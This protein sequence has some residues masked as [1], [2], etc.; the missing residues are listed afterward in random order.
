M[1]NTTVKGAE[2][3]HG[4]NPQ[5]LVERVIRARIYD[6]T[7]W[8]QDCF[9]LTAATLVD[10]AAEL[11]YVGGTY[12]MLR[13]SP[14][15]CLLLKM[16]QL[17]PEREIVL[18]YLGATELKYVAVLTRYLRAVAAMYVRLVFK[19]LDVYEILEPMLNDYHK[20]RWRDASGNFV[21]SHMDEFVDK[22]LTEERVCDL[23]LPRLARR[24]VVEENEGLRPRISPLEEALA[25][26]SDSDD[27][28][29]A[30]RQ[31]RR[32]RIAR[33]DALRATRKVVH[34]DYN[35]DYASQESDDEYLGARYRS[36]GSVSP[37]RR[38]ISPDRRSI[39]PDRRSVSPDRR[40]VS[41][42]RRSVSPDRRSVSPDR[43]SVSPDRRSIS[44]DRRSISP[45][46][47]VSPPA[48]PQKHIG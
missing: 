34:E 44:P 17:A 2:I 42:D 27:E 26:D 4:T 13:P 47:I 25:G 22:L 15:L 18:E 36:P 10:R 20:L 33:A 29:K 19:S 39:S 48:N 23:I 9:G 37:D 14:F 7:Y 6:S 1:A 31:A 5:F 28:L 30:V 41:P 35:F 16:L 11:Q 3:V 46:R 43:R 12:G 40:S 8:K 32:A 21:L 24:D 45:D 38:S